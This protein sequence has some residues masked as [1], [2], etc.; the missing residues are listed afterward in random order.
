MKIIVVV[1]ILTVLFLTLPG[2]V[3]ATAASLS[4]SPSTGTF[5]IGEQFTVDYILNTRTFQAFGADVYATY[6]STILE[7]V[8]TQSTPITSSTNW[9]SPTTNTIDTTLG[10]IHLD[11]GK[12]Q[13]AYSGSPSIGRVTF[14]AATAGQAQLNYIFFQQYD[15]T[16]PG[17]AKV[18]GKKDGVNLSN[19]LTDVT[20][21]IYV[22]S[23]TAPTATPG[24]TTPA[25]P[26]NTPGPTVP[27]VE[28]LPRAGG[29]K[30]TLSILPI[31][32]LFLA[33]GLIIP[34]TIKTK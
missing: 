10:K 28:E 16:T 29:E 3:L 27:P 24:P 14:K 6:D 1:F 17:V 13:S 23:Q 5:N 31:A 8:G 30:L 4:C 19:I 15:D 32:F 9:T 11:Y 18:W 21:C 25:G 12:N 2:E 34:A 7:A 26:T 33:I 22:V 20:N